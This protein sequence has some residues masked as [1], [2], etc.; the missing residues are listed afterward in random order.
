[1]SDIPY[2]E[3]YKKMYLVRSFEN[4]L[5][6][7]FSQ[8]KLNGTTHTYSGQEAIAASVISNLT[9]D[10]IV[11]SNHRGHGHY[12]IKENDPKGL[13]AEIMGKEGGVCGG[14]GGSQHLYR[15][16]Y[17]SNGVQGGTVANSLGMAFSEK[18]KNTENIV[19]VFIG[20][21]TLGEG[22]VYE[23]LNLASLWNVPLLIVVEN[24]QYAQTTS[25][26]DNLSGLMIK[27]AEAFDLN[28][29]EIESND[30]KYL[31]PLFQNIIDKIRSSKSPH[32]QIIHTYRQNAHSKGD[33]F[34]DQEEIDFWIKR[35]PLIYAKSKLDH[36]E[37]QIIEQEI[38]DYLNDIQQEVESMPTLTQL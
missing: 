15:N 26:K 24:N 11:F 7:L 25:I 32:L 13:L 27:R 33:D 37:L 2:K 16:N 35:D 38:E 17:Y 4:R 21:G 3:L 6:D 34:R 19:T 14:R 30:I 18:Y 10:D 36:T 31:Y 12:L 23:S 20:D 1:M 22:I 28:C 9:K 29:G 8:G 5:L